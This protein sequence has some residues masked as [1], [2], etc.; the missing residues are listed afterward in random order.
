[1]PSQHGDGELGIPAMD[2][3]AHHW[4]M[5][6]QKVN[7][8]CNRSVNSLCKRGTEAGAQGFRG[9]IQSLDE[10]VYG[11]QGTNTEQMECLSGG[12]HQGRAQEWNTG[13]HNHN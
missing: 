2:H 1:M 9:K 8:C 4:E 13:P 7:W 10:S 6:E 5:Q 11:K 12:T 3:R